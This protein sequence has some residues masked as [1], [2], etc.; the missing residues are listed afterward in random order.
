[1]AG[2]RWGKLTS[3]AISAFVSTRRKNSCP[4]S[5]FS[6]QTAAPGTGALPAAPVH[7]FLHGQTVLP[8]LQM[9]EPGLVWA[10]PSSVSAIYE[11]SIVGQSGDQGTA[12]RRSGVNGA[13]GASNES[14]FLAG[15][16]PARTLR[17]TDIGLGPK[18]PSPLTSAAEDAS[19]P[20]LHSRS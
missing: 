19:F 9:E 2:G 12:N 6:R 20:E 7:T 3:S 13:T 11:A 17:S 14:I 18:R 5:A 8:G 1:M 15:G 4:K 10:R 16:S